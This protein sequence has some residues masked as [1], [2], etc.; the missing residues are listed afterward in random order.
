MVVINE[1]I[2]EMGKDLFSSSDPA[3]V[4]KYLPE[5][6]APASM[7][8]FVLFASDDVVLIDAG[9]G[10]PNWVNKLTE[11]GVKPEKIKLI[12]L[13]HM[14]GDHIGGLLDGHTR[15]FPNATVLSAKLEYD[16]WFPKN[17]KARTSQLEKIKTAYGNDFSKTF[18]F[19]EQVFA[20]ATMKITALNAVGHTPGHTA[21]L[22]ES[23]QNRLLIVG[24]LLHAAALQF[25]VPD[26]CSSY[27][28][29]TK[30]TVTSRKRILDF[31]IKQNI[32]IG[33]MHFPVP[34][35]GKVKSN[36]QGGYEFI[37]AK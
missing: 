32:L 34:N 6:G 33:G 26:I 11:L 27:D 4:E 31:A 29:D 8:S 25:P 13:T 5:G 20:N 15:R 17:A 30:N 9:L 24:D 36:G 21:F 37:P 1:V 28:M 7:S 12:L 14:H 22:V 35:I 23:S 2:R 10:G 3:V 16:Y 18:E 19:D